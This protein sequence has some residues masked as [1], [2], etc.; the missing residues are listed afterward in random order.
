MS[1][2]LA[3]KKKAVELRTSVMSSTNEKSVFECK[4][5]DR[6]RKSMLQDTLII[7]GAIIESMESSAI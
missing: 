7:G 4:E 6:V 2:Y 3:Q 1:E 5:E